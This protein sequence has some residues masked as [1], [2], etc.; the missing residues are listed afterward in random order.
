MSPS[1]SSSLQVSSVALE[2]AKQ[3]KLMLRG[4]GPVAGL[5]ALT[6]SGYAASYSTQA[7]EVFVR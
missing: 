2:N 7:R 4:E 1:L 6:E 3:L 5:P